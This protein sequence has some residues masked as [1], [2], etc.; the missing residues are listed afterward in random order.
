MYSWLKPRLLGALRVPAEPHDPFGGEGTLLV[1][2]A[3]P[4]F[5]HYR[6]IGWG[7]RQALTIFGAIVGLG[8]LHGGLH[9]SRAPA[10]LVTGAT[11]VEL[12][13]LAV[14]ALQLVLSFV[15]LRLDFEMRW[16]KV[17][18][19]SLR[20]RE[21]VW[22]VR[23]LTMTFANV[24]NVSI[25]QGPLQRLFGIADVRVQS[26]GGGGSLPGGQEGGHHGALDLHAAVF[27]GVDNAETI[28]DLI[29]ERLRRLK[30]AGLGDREDERLH[31]APEAG[32]VGRVELLQAIREEAG[33]FRRAA[34]A[35][36]VHDRS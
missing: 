34:E 35:L 12:A 17:T 27:R 19:R 14:I 26:A 28:R 20:I 7:I 8:A 2:R 10:W 4:S 18:D 22:L 15:V 25:E 5:Y 29:R 30:D 16:Y 24:Q 31:A 23:E 3:A 32:A 21:G 13:G 9:A 1:F 11:I 6:L 36:A 33:A